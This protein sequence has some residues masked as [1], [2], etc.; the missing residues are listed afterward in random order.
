MKLNI[1]M[2]MDNYYPQINGVVTSAINTS[3][4]LER[5]GHN[6]YGVAP[7][8]ESFDDYQDD[9][10]PLPT[11][12]VK[13]FEIGV[14]PDFQFSW[15]FDG[16]L[17]NEMREFKPD[18]IHFHAP[19]P[20]GFQAI[21]IA[22][23]L[24]IPVIGTFHTFFAEP[25]YLSVVGLEKWKWL[26]R[27][28][29]WYSNFYFLRCDGVISP[30]IATA[31]FLK[32]KGLKN[33]IEIISNGVQGVKYRAGDFF[34]NTGFNLDDGNKWLLYVGRVSKEKCMDT[35]LEGFKIIHKKDNKTRLLI[36]GGGPYLNTLKNGIE[37]DGYKD[38]IIFTGSIPNKDLMESGI[39]KK[40]KMFVTAST[41]ENQPMTI[42]E[43]ICMGL[44]VVGADA[45]GIPELIEGN[46]FTF[47]PND[48]EDMAAKV[49]D[50]LNNN[51]L[52]EEFSKK[53]IELSLKYDITNTTVKMEN[54]YYSII[55]KYRG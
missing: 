41:S 3:I 52:Y 32:M 45:K 34:N 21:N 33:D 35:L 17:F 12:F 31:S 50:I 9:Y 51:D 54:F 14:Y 53:S 16:K 49:L 19:M 5:R 37:R 13:G 42:L 43:S 46:G 30:G 55:E 15:P 44:P 36:V 25:E 26:Q 48:P 47:K 8:P 4:E 20:I 39:Y 10:F 29:W 27:F 18:L 7:M 11:H 38:T 22:R 24:K 2:F 6:V 1:A 23:K 40:A 28:G